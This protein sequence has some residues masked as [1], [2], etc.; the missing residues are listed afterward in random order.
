MRKTSTENGLLQ[1]WVRNKAPNKPVSK[2]ET[3]ANNRPANDEL[4]MSEEQL[5]SDIQAVLTPDLLSKDYLK[6]WTPRRH[7]VWGHCYAA[8]EALFHML[9]GKKAGYASY[10]VN[11]DGESHWLIKTG[12]AVLDPTAGQFAGMQFADLTIQIV[13]SPCGFLTKQPS[14]RAAEIIRRVKKMRAT[15]NLYRIVR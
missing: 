10:H 14:T 15:L 8:S 1:T 7:R 12:N 3:N 2:V 13:S 6:R 9:G 4:T 5:I 11:V